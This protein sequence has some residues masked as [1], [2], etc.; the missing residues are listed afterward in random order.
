VRLRA[1]TTKTRR[2]VWVDLPPELAD[3]LE[4]TLPHRK[5]RDRR[6]SYSATRTLTCS[7]QQS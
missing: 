1:A 2:A 6:R 5:F 7:E 3:A 4:A